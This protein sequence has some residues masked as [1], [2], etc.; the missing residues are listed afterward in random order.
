MKA[1]L[2]ASEELMATR[3]GSVDPSKFPDEVFDLYS[4]P[5]YD[6]GEPEVA[7]GRSIGSTKQIVQPGDIL[8]SKIVPHIRRVWVVGESRGRRIIASG[9]WI[10]FRSNLII[11]RYLRHVL[12]G[13]TFHA[14]F[15]NT[16]SGVGGSLLRARPAF[17]AKIQI[18][19]P[20]KDEQKRIADIL[21]KADALR[22]KR[23]EA[24]S[25]INSL[26]QSIFLEMFGNPATNSKGWNLAPIGSFLESANYG[27]SQKAGDTGKWPILR[28]NNLTYS[29]EMD[30]SNLKYLDLVE[31]D[32]P[33]YTVKKGDILFNRT[34]SA[35]LVGKTAVYNEESPMAFAGYLVRLRCT[36]DN[37]P[38]YISALLNSEW[39][40]STLRG[41][42][43]SIIGMA[44]I[45]ATEIQKLVVPKPPGDLQKKFGEKIS[46]LKTH[47]GPQNISMRELDELFASIQKKVFSGE[48]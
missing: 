6:S 16:V 36:E 28:M 15:M 39:G 14:Q 41:M 35:E 20:S 9:E 48:L 47:K 43:K 13:N 17:V 3:L 25:L 46:I 26:T 31:K 42:C 11:A 37:H 24:I 40:K 22:A 34:N 33:K 4:I 7:L 27:S 23:R 12:L 44:N 19:I 8:L 1:R 21:D 38:E 29:G 18:P 10:V 5:A 2:A 45:N 32:V 30:F